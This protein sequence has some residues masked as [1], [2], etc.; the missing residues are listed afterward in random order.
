MGGHRQKRE[1]SVRFK[2]V[3]SMTPEQK[4][5]WKYFWAPI[6]STML[7]VVGGLVGIWLVA[8]L[9]TNIV[10][11][12]GTMIGFLGGS[13]F[14]KWWWLPHCGWISWAC[15]LVFAIYQLVRVAQQHY[16]SCLV[17]VYR[18]DHNTPKYCESPEEHRLHH[19]IGEKC[20]CSDD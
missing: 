17:K 3:T 6:V 20:P 19:T 11:I 4:R 12:F 7:E 14:P 16:K 9:V 10:Y 13:K 15:L 5:A 1:C 2:D 18:E 8:T